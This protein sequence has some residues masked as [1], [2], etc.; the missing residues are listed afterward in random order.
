MRRAGAGAGG[1]V[2]FNDG[3]GGKSGPVID[4][5]GRIVVAIADSD[6]FLFVFFVIAAGLDDVFRIRAEGFALRIILVDGFAR[7]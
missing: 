3:I 4:A 7:R 6:A 5:D 1:L 2:V